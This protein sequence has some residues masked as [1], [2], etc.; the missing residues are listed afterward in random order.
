[1]APLN[2]PPE[3]AMQPPLLSAPPPPIATPLRLNLTPPMRW[4]RAASSPSA[5][6][7]ALDDARANPP[8]ST[9]WDRLAQNLA[10]DTVLREEALGPDRRRFR[11]GT[12]CIEAHSTR[13]A[14]LNPFD[15]RVRDL[16][17]AKPCD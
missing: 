9:H 14:R 2:V 12:A 10:A 4:S 6:D 17:V 11:K 15:D 3:V 5:R 8:R 1:M 13:I 7:Q 16:Q